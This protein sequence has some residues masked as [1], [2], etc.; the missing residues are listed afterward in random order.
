MGGSIFVD[1]ILGEGSQFYFIFPFKEVIE[2]K[3]NDESKL[4]LLSPNF[5]SILKNKTIL[6]AEDEELIRFY[7][8]EVIKNYKSKIIF[9]NNG[10]EAVRCFS[11][12][13]NIDLVLM[14]LNMPE[15]NG[16][17]ATKEI[18]KMNTKIKIIAQTAFASSNEKE[19]CI[20]SGFVDYI[21]KPL[22]TEFIISTIKNI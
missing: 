1:S 3:D 15:M 17:K 11:E 13:K 9:A 6:I 4:Q 5:D 20:N 19:K 14:N 2:N 7:F 21:T 12:N 10:V 8:R 16:Y 22:S 18:L